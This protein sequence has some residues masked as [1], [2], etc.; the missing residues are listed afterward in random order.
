MQIRILSKK[1]NTAH[2]CNLLLF[3]LWLMFQ[4]AFLIALYGLIPFLNVCVYVVRDLDGGSLILRF[5]YLKQTN[6]QTKTITA[7]K[8]RTFSW[9]L[10]EI[11]RKRENVHPCDCLVG[12]VLLVCL[13]K[14]EYPWYTHTLVQR[15]NKHGSA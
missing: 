10:Q 2:D 14:R 1:T 13:G 9:Y 12:P 4:R 11:H 15:Q 7:F 3:M 8:S 6:K 5:V